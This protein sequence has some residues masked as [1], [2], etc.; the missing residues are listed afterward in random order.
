M[1]HSLIEIL[2]LV[3]VVGAI[4]YILSILPIDATLKTIGRVVVLV[5][6]A[7][8]AI[9]MLMPLLH[10]QPSR[11]QR[12]PMEEFYRGLEGRQTNPN[13]N[14][15]VNRRINRNGEIVWLRMDCRGDNYRD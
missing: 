7:I 10:A 1:P 8:Y 4:L 2:I 3:I 11:Y 6:A 9:T 5:I 13:L 14:C 15:T 12:N